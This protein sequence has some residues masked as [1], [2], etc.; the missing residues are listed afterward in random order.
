MHIYEGAGILSDRPKCLIHYHSEGAFLN[1]GRNK[2]LERDGDAEF[3][4]P[5]LFTMDLDFTPVHYHYV[6]DD[7]EP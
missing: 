6:L 5:S 2:K 3:T 4:P 7:A 1:T